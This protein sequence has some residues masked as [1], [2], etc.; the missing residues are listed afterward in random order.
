MYEP[1]YQITDHILNLISEIEGFRSRTNACRILPEREVE[2]RYR[3][4]VEATHSSTSIEGN[5]LSLKQ[6][7]HAL[8]NKNPLTRRRY[9]EIEVRNYRAALGWVDRRKAEHRPISVEDILTLHGLISKNLLT[10]DREGAWR[11]YPVVLEDQLTGNINYEGA[12][13]AEVPT[14]VGQLVTWLSQRANSLHP[15][16]AAAILH[17]Q[18]LAIHPFADANGRTTRALTSLYLGLRN[19]DFRGA[20]VLDS[21]YS[22]DRS[23]YYGALSAQGKT[24]LEAERTDLTP[25]ITYFAEGFLSSARILS[26]ETTIL[27]SLAQNPDTSTIS[28]DEMELLNYI[29]Q[30]GAITIS[31]AEEILW[32]DTRRTIQRKLSHL[33]ELGYLRK[34]G[35]TRNAKYFKNT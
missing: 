21:Y 15:V 19:Y 20:I 22:S 23:A 8:H 32:D 1:K 2:L 16:V 29:E 4:T 14:L 13:V 35:S 11:K 6:V 25:W 12:P 24:F 31:E 17:Y 33:V 18:L 9:A 3:S 30:F 10:S 34:E 26:A 28:R 5:P 7:R 27:S